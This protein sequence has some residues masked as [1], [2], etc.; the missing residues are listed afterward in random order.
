M[1]FFA[2]LL[3]A[4]FIFAGTTTPDSAAP[5]TGAVT[6]SAKCAGIKSLDRLVVEGRRRVTVRDFA[7]TSH[8]TIDSSVLLNTPGTA[9]DI[10]RV[11]VFHPSV[12]STGVYNDNALY[13]RGGQPT[14]NAYVID[15]MVFDD[16]NHYTFVN[17]PGGG[18][19]FIDPDMVDRLEIYAGG[20]PASRPKGTTSRIMP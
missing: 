3:A 15:G 12:L 7:A 6:D 17:R 14:E 18:F 11:I 13:V 16:I 10:N 1:A 9:N 5:V 19:G 2:L 4:A 8:T 20:M